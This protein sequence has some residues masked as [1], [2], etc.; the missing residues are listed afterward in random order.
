MNL[1]L[2]N[3][4]PPSRAVV[5]AADPDDAWS[6]WISFITDMRGVYIRPKS[7]IVTYLGVASDPTPRVVCSSVPG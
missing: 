2:V 1:Y 3:G 7:A 5:V 4:A 6:E